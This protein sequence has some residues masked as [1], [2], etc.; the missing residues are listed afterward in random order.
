M[1]KL[2]IDLDSLTMP[3]IIKLVA[4]FEFVGLIDEARVADK[5]YRKKYNR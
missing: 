1:D 3:Q 2:T 5:F 4:A